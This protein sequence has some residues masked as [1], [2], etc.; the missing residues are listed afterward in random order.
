MFY[1]I[2]LSGLLEFGIRTFTIPVRGR[3]VDVRGRAL[4]N[5]W[6]DWAVAAVRSDVPIRGAVAKRFVS[7]SSSSSANVAEPN[8]S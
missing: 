5:G 7:K 8:M 4:D 6:F 3:P 2:F 1:L